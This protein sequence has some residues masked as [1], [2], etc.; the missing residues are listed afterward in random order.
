[1]KKI[2]SLIFISVLAIFP[3]ACFGWN[4]ICGISIAAFR[5]SSLDTKWEAD[6]AAIKG[7]SEFHGAIAELQGI[8]TE[9]ILGKSVDKSLELN[10]VSQAVKKFEESNKQLDLAVEKAQKLIISAG[11]ADNMGR[12]SMRLWQELHRHNSKFIKSLRGKQLPE[13]EELHSA[14]EITQQIGNIGMRASLLHLGQN[15]MQHTTGGMNATF[16]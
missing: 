13:L 3:G 2:V 7:I 11:G 9:I 14:I 15:K 8:N 5:A 16:K 10:K 12:E 4:I 6:T 1:M